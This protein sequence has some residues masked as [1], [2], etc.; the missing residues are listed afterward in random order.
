MEGDWRPAT[1]NERGEGAAA[2]RRRQCIIA[3]DIRLLQT[4]MTKHFLRTTLLA[5]A[6][7]TTTAGCGIV[8]RQPI[9]QGNLLDKAAV[10]QLQVGMGKQQVL[11]LLG[12]PSVQDPYHPDRWDYT[13]SQRTDR[14]ANTHTKN[15]TLW[16]DESDALVKWDGDYFPKQDA[17][18]AKKSVRQFG[19]NLAKEKKKR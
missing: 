8:Y 12:T 2:A 15:L 10:E 1:R 11:G 19:R 14:L 6:V 7:A 13:A 9:Y 17:E 16:F 18:L 3:L 5:L 4:P